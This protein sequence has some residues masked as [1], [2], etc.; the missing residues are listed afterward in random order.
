MNET[1]VNPDALRAHAERVGRLGVRVESA[2]AAAEYLTGLDDAYSVFGR[3][4]VGALLS[5][6]HEPAIA[7]IDGVAKALAGVGVKLRDN[8]NEFEATDEATR[9]EFEKP[10][11]EISESNLEAQ[12]HSNGTGAEAD[13]AP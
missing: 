7:A 2:L 5:D 12:D 9:K 13:G 6:A 10:H 3:P 1:H 8:A 11:R 4:F